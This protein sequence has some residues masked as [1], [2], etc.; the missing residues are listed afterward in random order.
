MGD[1]IY[2]FLDEGGNFDFSKIGTKYF[3]L[4]CVTQRRPFEILSEFANYRYDIIEHGINQ[5]FFH[6][7]ED[8]KH[9]RGRVFDIISDHIDSIRIDSLIVEKAKAG[10]ALRPDAEFY[11]RMLGYLLGHVIEK[12]DRDDL[13]E[14]VVITDTI[15]VN[16]KRKAIEKAIKTTLKKMLPSTAKYRVYHHSS[17]SHAMLQLADYC[18]WAIY[19][20]WTA[21]DDAAYKMIQKSIKSEFDIFQTGRTYYY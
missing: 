12:V 17:R 18:N 6:A 14:I 1:V 8:N 11:P 15:P 7:A 20:K 3:L 9:I 21:G 19:R 4:T 16:R 10:P 5:E 13:K 2:V